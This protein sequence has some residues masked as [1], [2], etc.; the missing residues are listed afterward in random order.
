MIFGNLILGGFGILISKMS[1]VQTILSF[2]GCDIEVLRLHTAGTENPDTP[3][4]IQ[5]PP[6]SMNITQTPPDTHQTSPRHPPYI[7]REQEM[8]TDNNR[9]HQTQTDSP[10]HPKTLKSAVWSHPAVS[11]GVICCLLASAREILQVTVS[12]DRPVIHVRGYQQEKRVVCLWFAKLSMR[13]TICKLQRELLSGHLLLSKW[14][15]HRLSHQSL[16]VHRPPPWCHHP[17]LMRMYCKCPPPCWYACTCNAE[18]VGHQLLDLMAFLSWSAVLK[19]IRD[20][21]NILSSNGGRAVLPWGLLHQ[22]VVN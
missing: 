21:G 1:Q 16:L 19:P 12:L 3:K 20:D 15:S 14:T 17:I 2:Q 22:L 18:W 9:R 7:S 6:I 5:V 8:P 13:S 11:V 10:R 4:H